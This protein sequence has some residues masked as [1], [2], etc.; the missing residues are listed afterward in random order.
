MDPENGQ[1]QRRMYN[2][3]ESLIVWSDEHL[4]VINKPAGLRSIID[5][6]DASLPHLRSEFEPLLG[7]LWIVHRL[8]KDTSGLIVIARNAKAHRNLNLQFDQSR[9]HKLYHTVVI[10]MPEWQTKIITLPLRKDGDRQHRTIVDRQHG[11]PARTEFAVLKMGNGRCLL[12]VKPYTGRTH[13]IRAH[14]AAIGHPI[15]NDRLYGNQAIISSDTRMALHAC[16]LGFEHPITGKDLSFQVPDP[17]LFQR[18][19]HDQCTGE[20]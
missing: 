12:E 20:T 10:G 9:V 4:V 18:L 6:Y 8:D 11:K 2:K 3:N 16:T 13:Q 1:T 5:G 15:A 19:L 17:D 7:R 14:L